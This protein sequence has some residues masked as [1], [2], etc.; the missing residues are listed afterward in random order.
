MSKKKPSKK[1]PQQQPSKTAE[2][3]KKKLSFINIILWNLLKQ[4]MTV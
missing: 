1:Q 2:I 4:K 3:P